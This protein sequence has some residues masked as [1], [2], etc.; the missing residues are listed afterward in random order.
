M[1][2]RRALADLAQALKSPVPENRLVLFLMAQHMHRAPV[3]C[4]QQGALHTHSQS[5]GFLSLFKCEQCRS[6]PLVNVVLTVQTQSLS[7][8][9]T[10]AL[11]LCG[12]P[13][14]VHLP[15]LSYHMISDPYSHGLPIYFFFSGETSTM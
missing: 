10:V 1:R 15:S 9:K 14:A 7:D 6:S 3:I 2:R 4:L 5:A 8:V 11:T 13:R 12:W